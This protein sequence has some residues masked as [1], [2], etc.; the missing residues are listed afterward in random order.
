MQPLN[1]PTFKPLF[2]SIGQKKYIFDRFRKKFVTLNP[3]EWV[4]QH[5][6]N[7][8]VDYQGVPVS[9]VAIESPIKY[10]NMHK[11]ADI[12]VYTKRHVP[13][14]VV[15]CKAPEIKLSTETFWQVATYNMVLKA[16]YLLVTNGLESYLFCIDLQT[17]QMKELDKL[18]NFLEW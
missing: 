9:L 5:V 14:L 3:E 10:N 12:I 8:L 13:G 17:N 2:K 1:Y 18:P 16:P 11:R 6:A 4:R 15:E 7:Y